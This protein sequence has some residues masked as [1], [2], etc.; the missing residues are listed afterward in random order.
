VDAY[1]VT[2]QGFDGL[3]TILVV[4]IGYVLQ[5]L[6]KLGLVI[7]H[8]C[9]GPFQGDVLRN[10]FPRSGFSRTRPMTG[11]TRR[12]TNVLHTFTVE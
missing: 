6:E 3:K 11:W 8:R 2:K 1:R 4:Q 9:D 12:P 5:L 7:N 10:Q